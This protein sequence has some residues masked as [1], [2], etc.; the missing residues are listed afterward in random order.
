[1][2][3]A[4]AAIYWATAGAVAGAVFLPSPWSILCLAAALTFLVSQGVMAVMA[5]RRY[6]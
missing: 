6:V 2:N 3:W 5:G 4:L 1:V